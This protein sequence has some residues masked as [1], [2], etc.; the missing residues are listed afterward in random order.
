MPFLPQDTARANNLRPVMFW[1]HGGEFTGGEGTGGV[2]EGGN[3][4]SRSDVVVVCINY[5]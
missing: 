2:Y 4:A 1:I 3:M 5:R